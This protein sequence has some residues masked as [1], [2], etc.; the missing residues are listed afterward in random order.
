MG[1]PLQCLQSRSKRPAGS[2]LHSP[3]VWLLIAMLFVLYNHGR[4][5]VS[6]KLH[7]IVAVST[8][9]IILITAHISDFDQFLMQVI[10]FLLLPFIGA[11]TNVALRLKWKTALAELVCTVYKE[12]IGGEF[13]SCGHIH[14]SWWK[15]SLSILSAESDN[16]SFF[17]DR[18][19][20]HLWLKKAHIMKDS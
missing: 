20:R 1:W 7:L 4:R 16:I 10:M 11:L 3:L 2:L 6:S 12:K 15:V 9:N 14:S 8:H 17:V 5:Q 19:Y 13:L 18:F